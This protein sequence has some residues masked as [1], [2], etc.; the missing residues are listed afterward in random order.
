MED[1]V[2]LDEVKGQGHYVGAYLAWQQNNSGWWG[3]GEIKIF[4]DGDKEFPTICGTGTEDYFG[5]AWGFGQNFSAPFLGYPSGSCDG[6]SGNRHI[7]YRFHIMDP[8][9]FKKGIKV[10]IQDDNGSPR[11]TKTKS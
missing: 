11:K 1:Y 7:L 3:E 2:I 5:G 10:I 9:R 4:M 6:K 8:I